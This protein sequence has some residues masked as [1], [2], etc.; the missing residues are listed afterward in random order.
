M[1]LINIYAKINSNYFLNKKIIFINQV[2][3][4]GELYDFALFIVKEK[5]LILFK[6]KY[7]I[8]DLN[9]KHKNEYFDSC[10]VIKGLF[11]DKFGIDLNGV[12]LLYISDKEA[13]ENNIECSTILD[14]KEMNCLFF[15]IQDMNFTFDF[16]H[17]IKEIK[18]DEAFRIIPKGKYTNKLLGFQRSYDFQFLKRKKYIYLQVLQKKWLLI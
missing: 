18:C 9:I 16:V 12:Y 8:K 2:D 3:S 6:A 14:N 13:N 10:K 15:S 7:I 1:N 11:K 4:I 17:I 5:N